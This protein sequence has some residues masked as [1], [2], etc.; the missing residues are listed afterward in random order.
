[1]GVNPI[2]VVRASKKGKK[3]Y[4]AGD[5]VRNDKENEKN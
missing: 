3:N 4:V 5:N 2:K 1:M